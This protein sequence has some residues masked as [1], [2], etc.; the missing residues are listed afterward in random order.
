MR[1]LVCIVLIL[2]SPLMLLISLLIKKKMGS[3]ILYT[4]ERSGKDGKPFMIYKFRSMTNE[5]DANGEL[6]PNYQRVTSLGEFLRK[7]SLDELPQ[8]I[9]V[10]KGDITLVGPR[11]LHM[12]YNDKYNSKQKKRLEVLP[13]ITGLA[14]INGRNNISWEEK[15]DYDVRYVENRSLTLDIKIIAKTI[16]KILK[17][18][19]INPDNQKETPRFLGDDKLKDEVN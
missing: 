15:F 12:E 16:I 6:L 4:Q 13:G 11:P 9:N 14:Q 5:V 17:K 2:I 10:I 19:D 7:S 8:L 3:P 1:T 18:S